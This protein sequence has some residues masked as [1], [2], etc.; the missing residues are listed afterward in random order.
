M[1]H[2][3]AIIFADPKGLGPGIELLSI[4]MRLMDHRPFRGRTGEED[5]LAIAVA[6]YLRAA[7]LEG[8]LRATWTCIPHEVG[9]VRPG[10]KEFNVAQTRYAKAKA[11]GLITGS[12]DYVFVWQGGGGWI[13]LKAPTGSLKPQQRDFRDWSQQ[14]GSLWAKCKTIHEVINTLEGWGV[15]TR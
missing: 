15:L 8:R 9:A 12:A 4:I 1:Q 6:N 5:N 2:L 10:S 13:E 3:V 14:T 7:T 11:M